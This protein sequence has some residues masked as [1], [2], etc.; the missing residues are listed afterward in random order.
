M[1]KNNTLSDAIQGMID[2]IDRASAYAGVYLMKKVNND[3]KN[4]ARTSVDKYYEYEN[5]YY[6]KYERQYRLY[7]TYDVKTD[8]KREG[9]NIVISTGVYMNSDPLEGLYHSNASEK[10]ADVDAEYV[11]KNFVYGR[12]PWTN[13]WPLSG[14]QELEYKEIK[15][16]PSPD[17]YLRNYV[18]NYSK[19]YF[20]K[21]IQATL[22]GLLKAYM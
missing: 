17:R 16:R 10:W 21:H 2:D 6:T 14:V 4:A 20:S 12:H 18:E 11:F 5:G 9:S 13:G 22:D 7:N 3:F 15:S 19:A 8:V 1:A